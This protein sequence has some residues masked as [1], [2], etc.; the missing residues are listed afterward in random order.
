MQKFLKANWPLIL[1][2]IY[3]LSPIDLLPE[4][5]P[6][7]GNILGSVDDATLVLIQGILAY[8]NSQK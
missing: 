3:V 4:A 2:A 6:A 5:L 1:V 8:K 7:I